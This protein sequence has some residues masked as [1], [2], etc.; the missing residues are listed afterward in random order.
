[1][2]RLG[3]D[4]N[5]AIICATIF[6]NIFVRFMWDPLLPL[7]LRALGA[8]A[9]EIGF[10]FTLMFLARTGF[11]IIGGAL[12]DRHGRVIVA[13]IT[14]IGSGVF[15]LAAAFTDD[16]IALIGL[17]IGA[18][19]LSSIQWPALSALITESAGEDKVTRS[20]SITE[21]AVL[22]GLIVGPIAGAILLAPLKIP[23]LFI[24]NGVVQTGCGIWRL[25][26][27]RET[28]HRA[29]GSVLL[30]LRAAM[31]TN[32]RWL[33]VL[34]SLIA[35]SF[36]IPFGPFFAILARDGWNN[37]E[38]E[39]NLIWAAGSV[40]S[41]AGIALGRM[42]ERWGARRV[43]VI[44]AIGFGIGTATWGL[45]PTWQLG[46]VPLLIAFLFSE[47]I[48]LAQQTLQAASTSRETRSSVYGM[49]ST[50]TGFVGGV[51]PSF[52]AWLIVLGGNALPF[53]IAGA[54]GVLCALAVMPIRKK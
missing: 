47:A 37:S 19:A 4:R 39:I 38:E 22:T 13:G 16:W 50:T 51:G 1:M 3:M 36:A 11:A 9:P 8:N 43:L 12:A 26:A 53:L 30:N 20:F 2:N 34:G 35:I 54:L 52:G 28:A 44:S 40:A 31:D 21:T 15:T 48:F 25:F 10:A 14:T 46:I 24:I 32:V 45:A 23:G 27:L 6:L 18:S 5:L 29:R 41:L 33:I 7:H 17:L 49:I 42:S